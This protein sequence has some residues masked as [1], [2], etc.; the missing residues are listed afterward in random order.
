MRLKTLLFV[1]LTILIVQYTFAQ[2]PNSPSKLYFYRNAP[3]YTQITL[4]WSDNSS[5]ETGFVIESKLDGGSWSE[6]ATIVAN[7]TT[8]Q[9]SSV[10]PSQSICYRVKAISS[11]ASSNYSNVVRL[12]GTQSKLEVYP[13]VP[14]IR[15][16]KDTTAF[17]LTFG[18]IQDQCPADPS[19]GKTTKL[20]EFYSVQV[21]SSNG[22]NFVSSPVYETHP[23]IR[24]YKSQNDPAH[25]A[26]H[27]PYGYHDYGPEQGTTKKMHGIHWTNFDAADEVVVRV[28]LLTT[29]NYSGPINMSDLEI[30]PAPLS[31]VK[32]DDYNIDITLPPADSTYTRHYR[33]NINRK[34]WAA[35]SGRSENSFEAPLYVFINPVQPAPASAPMD[36]I[37]TF[38]NGALVVYGAGIHLPNNT[39]RFFGTNGNSTCSELYAPGDAYI[40]GGYIFNNQTYAMRVWGRAIY[41]DEM[42]DIYNDIAASE[43]YEYST[44]GRTPWS[45]VNCTNGNP[46]NK[47]PTSWEGRVGFYCNYS[48]PTIFEGFT[49]IGGRMGTVNDGGNAAIINHKDVGYGGGTY[50]I[51][52]GSKTQYLGCLL[53]NDDDI[54]YVH[55][56]FTMDHCTS[57]ILHNGPSFQCGWGL[58]NEYNIKTT[59]KNHVA[60]A[61]D[62]GTGAGYGKNHGVID[63]RLKLGQLQYH[64]GGVMENLDVWGEENI[65][66]QLR[67]WDETIT[68]TNTT[69]I[70][71][72]KVYKNFNIHTASRSKNILWGDQNTTNNQQS[73][74]RFLHFDNLIIAGNHIDSINDG[75]Y[76]T[77]NSGVLLHT[78]T[79]F[80]LPA[81]VPAPTPGVAPIGTAINLY[82]KLNNKIVR[83]DVSLPVSFGPLCANTTDVTN[84]FTVVDAGGGYIALKTG[85]GNCVK[86]DNKRYGY[87]RT[88]ADTKRADAAAT[89][90]TEDA[91]FIW[92][93]LGNNNFALYSKIMGLYLRVEKGSGPNM[94]LYAASAVVGNAETFVIGESPTTSIRKNSQKRI[95]IYPNPCSEFIV[96]DAIEYDTKFEIFNIQGQLIQT[97]NLHYGQ[98]EIDISTCRKGS[99]IVKLS[100][101]KGVINEKLIV[102]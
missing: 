50:Q 84:S 58:T 97:E 3:T 32:V 83:A 39:Y 33:V 56:N 65:V 31:V 43:N 77:Y 47:V 102:R 89:S 37:K 34:V 69:S 51:G 44:A 66:F 2:T 29:G 100:D 16:P 94:P 78:I 71:E 27:R 55:L 49:N 41:S 1:L 9:F 60:L 80:S 101:S 67:I 72:D 45:T 13:E 88:L 70:F 42:Y 76:F 90:L 23:Q 11:S 64:S 35:A 82:S 75:N 46:W 81:P 53:V 92:V 48:Q 96:I 24:N 14:G 98:N 91:K 63:S 21:R 52:S 10:D 8:Y 74:L 19:K 54:T 59:I 40:H 15:N 68:N 73:Y 4:Y 38:N 5:D 99:Y 22:T 61:S 95:S 36:E 6:V 18:M 7:T 26:G 20:S 17:G 57:T 79:F 12:V 86:A 93:D 30:S 87:V 62:R 85:N 25:S 28:T